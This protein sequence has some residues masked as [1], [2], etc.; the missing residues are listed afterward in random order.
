MSMVEIDGNVV[1][2]GRLNTEKITELVGSVDPTGTRVIAKPGEGG[3]WRPLPELWTDENFSSIQAHYPKAPVKALFSIGFKH[4]SWYVTDLVMTSWLSG[5]GV[6]IVDDRSFRYHL[7][8]LWLTLGVDSLE[9]I[10]DPGQALI[11]LMAHLHGVADQIRS[12]VR[13]GEK[14]LMSSAVMSLY[15]LAERRCAEFGHPIGEVEGMIDD[16]LSVTDRR[17]V[18]LVDGVD[19]E[20][21]QRKTVL[22]RACCLADR[23]DVGFKCPDCNLDGRDSQIGA[24]RAEGWQL[25]SETH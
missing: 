17:L 10:T 3:S 5:G 18:E 4:Y 23:I 15:E 1:L 13:L 25:N 12:K 21:V 11:G 7:D 9:T 20:G 22:R 14:A 2:L 19:P 24:L 8:N 6:V 16:V